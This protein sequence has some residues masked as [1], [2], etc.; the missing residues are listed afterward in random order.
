MVLCGNGFSVFELPL[1]THTRGK[2]RS[3]G[4]GSRLVMVSEERQSWGKLVR[5]K[6]LICFRYI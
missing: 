1:H 2:V 3:R 5:E 4:V 6:R